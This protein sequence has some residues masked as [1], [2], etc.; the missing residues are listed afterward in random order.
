MT[1]IRPVDVP[2]PAKLT[3]EQFELLDRSGAFDGYAKAE[4]IE[5]A[6]YVMQSPSQ[7]SP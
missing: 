7:A 4:L 6:I 1:A 5:G 3:I 2:Q